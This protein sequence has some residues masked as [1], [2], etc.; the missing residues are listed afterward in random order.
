MRAFLRFCPLMGSSHIAGLKIAC[1]DSRPTAKK[2]AGTLVP[3][4]KNLLGRGAK[5][6]LCRGGL[7]KGA[8]AGMTGVAVGAVPA[9]ASC[10]P[11]VAGVPGG[12]SPAKK[13]AFLRMTE[14]S[15]GGAPTP[16]CLGA[17][18]FTLEAAYPS[19]GVTCATASAWVISA[20]PLSKSSRR[21]FQLPMPS[22]CI[23][24]S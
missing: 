11:R 13:R 24:E 21:Y 10:P 20:S 4:P 7:S 22:S 5:A 3:R 8:L 2:L 17:K 19:K 12:N 6:A 1:W 15:G 9:E 14:L 16:K 23:Y 18:A